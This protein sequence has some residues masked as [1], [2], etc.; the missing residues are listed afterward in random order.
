MYVCMSCIH[1]W[2]YTCMCVYIYVC[3]HVHC[4]CV[5]M[6]VCIHVRVYTCMCVYMYMCIHV[7]VYELHTC[8]CIRAAYI[9]VCASYIHLWVY[10]CMCVYMYVCMSYIHVMYMCYVIPTSMQHVLCLLI[11][12]VP[13]PSSPSLSS[14]P[15]THLPTSPLSPFLPRTSLHSLDYCRL[16]SKAILDGRHEMAMLLW[17][18]PNHP[19]SPPSRAPHG[20]HVASMEC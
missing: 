2:V 4:T 13:P 7:C 8:M 10:T 9:Y 15:P 12:P 18:F 3:I 5:Y 1:V 20:Y 6:Y 19:P 17:S 16:F 14:F 11:S